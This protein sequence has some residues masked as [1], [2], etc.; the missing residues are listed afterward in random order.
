MNHSSL[1]FCSTCANPSPQKH[2]IVIVEGFLLFPS[3]S[4][5]MLN[6]FQFKFFIDIDYSTMK[7]RRSQRLYETENGVQLDPPNYFDSNVWPSYK[8]HNDIQKYKN[9]GIVIL[10]G[11]LQISDLSEQV[12]QK[13][14]SDTLF[15]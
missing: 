15:S 6:S 1:K 5:Q 9:S 4:T 3:L 7:K 8:T 13:M 14:K 10:D 12:L 11:N 2:H